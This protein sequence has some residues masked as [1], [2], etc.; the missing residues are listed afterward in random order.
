MNERTTHLYF[1]WLSYNVQS[2]PVVIPAVV[3][4]LLLSDLVGDENA[5]FLF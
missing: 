2:F 3:S 4:E 5:L 1:V